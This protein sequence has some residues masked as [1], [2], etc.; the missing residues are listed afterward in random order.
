[1]SIRPCNDNQSSMTA[2]AVDHPGNSHSSSRFAGLVLLAVVLLV[3]CGI[4]TP[5]PSGESEPERLIRE[6]GT[7]LVQLQHKEPKIL[8]TLKNIESN[9]RDLRQISAARS[10]ET[11]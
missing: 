9:S 1:M 5:K 6:L 4:R 3:G 2:R 7:T 8:N 10:L 11:E